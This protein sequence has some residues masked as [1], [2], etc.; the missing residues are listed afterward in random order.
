MRW[1]L[2]LL[3]FM[4]LVMT[5]SADTFV[6]V[7]MTPEQKIQIYRLDA[8][9][10]KLTPVE[11]QAVDGAPGSLGVDPAKKNLFA[12]LR[13]KSTLAS[14]RID[15]AT[16]KLKQTS[17]AALGKGENAAFVG[18]DRSGRWLISAS[19]AAGKVVVHRLNDDGTI[20]SPAVQTVETAK[21]AHSF[22]TDRDNRFV[23]VPH[24]APNAVYQFRLDAATGK[25]T[26]AGKA[27]GGT[28]KAGPRHLAFHP[29]Q[30]LAFSSDE[31]GSSITA[32]RFD[33]ATGLKPVQTLSTLPAD[34]KGENS[35][36]EVKVHPSGKFVWV[37]NRGHDSLAGFAI[38]SAGKLTTLGQTPT[39]KTPRSFDIE[40]DGRFVLSAGEG[41]GKLAVFAVDL[42]SGKLTRVQT[43]DVGKS[44]SWVLAAKPGN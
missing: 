34:F 21:T 18:T 35:T 8:K 22:V 9:D 33:P 37:S 4:G 23:F 44:L 12:S 38:D 41:S 17:S 32:Y 40:P 43:N 3:L 31:S 25:L 39:E 20:Q 11:T 6:Y 30:N 15:P 36:A 26:D 13:S 29:T 16:G 24:V 14:Y 19:Y 2:T 27:P 1:L 42:D 28:D 10:G 7:S 5:L